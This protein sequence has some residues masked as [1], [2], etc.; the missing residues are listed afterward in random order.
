MLQNHDLGNGHGGCSAGFHTEA[1][2]P[3]QR[4][5][6]VL[7]GVEGG[8]GY[9]EGAGGRAGV[10]WGGRYVLVLSSPLPA[11]VSRKGPTSSSPAPGT[12]S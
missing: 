12:R 1:A 4:G 11:L 2:G 6:R 9:S 8:Q 3:P 5:P 7:G 10:N